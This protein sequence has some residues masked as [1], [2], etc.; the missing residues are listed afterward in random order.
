MELVSVIITTF[1][2]AKN[3]KRAID[4]VINKTYSHFE[5]IIVDDNNPE[6]FARKYTE[7]IISQYNDKRLNYIKHKKNMN[8]AV[9]R[10]TGIKYSKGKYISFL[11]NDDFY[12]LD[13]LDRCVSILRNNNQ[14][15][16]IYTNTIYVINKKIIGINRVKDTNNPSKS[17]LL[18]EKFLGTGSNIFIKKSVITQLNGFDEQFIRHQDLEFILRALQI[19]K[20]YPLSENLVIKDISNKYN[21]PKY[22]KYC[23]AKAMYFKK[24]HYL[25]KKLSD[26]ERYKFFD[27]QYSILFWTALDENNKNDIDDAIINLKKVRNLSKVEIYSIKFNNIRTYINSIKIKIKHNFIFYNFILCAKNLVTGRDRKLKR[28]LDSQILMEIKKN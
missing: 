19:T 15:G 23:K 16:I 1:G 10:N 11:D 26:E 7:K 13:R 28:N 8:G 27:Y 12:I 9:A 6:S 14:Y 25:I 21:I 22:K 4:S 20:I 3:L 17:I 5:I 2:V 18:N 24:F